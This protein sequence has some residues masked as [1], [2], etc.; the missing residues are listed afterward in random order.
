MEQAWRAHRDELMAASRD[1]GTRPYGFF[2]FDLRIA[3]AVGHFEQIGLL[4]ERG[5]I[6]GMEAIC[7]ERTYSLLS[8]DAPAD[9]ASSFDSA[10]G[11][12]DQ[13][14]TTR[15]LDRLDV[16]ARWHAWRGRPELH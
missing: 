14:A 16:A 2:K 9:F 5:L 11:V 15:T 6:D 3:A 10:D 13:G 7:I 1:P 8:D 12:R 4:V